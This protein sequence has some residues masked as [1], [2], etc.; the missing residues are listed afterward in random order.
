VLLS[1]LGLA[2]GG[3]GGEDGPGE[4]ARDMKVELH[5][6]QVLLS[7]PLVALLNPWVKVRQGVLVVGGPVPSAEAARRAV[8]LMGQVRGVRAVRSE[9]YVSRAGA[10]E[11]DPYRLPAKSDPVAQTQSAS[12]D[13]VS[14]NVGRLTGLTPAIA[15]PPSGRTAGP[16]PAPSPQPPA[17][18]AP[19]GDGPAAAQHPVS[20]LPPV[21]VTAPAPSPAP[22]ATGPGPAPGVEPLADAIERVRQ[23]NP[24][25]RGVRIELQGATVYVGGPE[26]SGENVMALAQALSALPG[27]GRVV[28][29]SGR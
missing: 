7:D 3:A 28:V 10:R 17:V 19:T 1:F 16:R 9:L 6:R 26:A 27:V 13:P 18:T 4:F 11:D 8:E 14:G 21:A 22:K 2:A 5:A 23:G 29:R 24:R 20:L 25:F 12:P 15:L